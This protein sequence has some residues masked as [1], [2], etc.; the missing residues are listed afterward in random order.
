MK[1][2][3]VISLAAI[4][5]LNAASIDEAFV[6]GKVSGQIRAAYVS[7]NN[8]VD[9]DTYGTSIGGILKYETAAWNDITLGVGAYVSQKLNF[10][11][12]DFDEG[13]ANSDLFGEDT[14]SYAYIGEG[15]IDYSANDIAVRVGRQLIDTPFADTDNIRMHPNTF[16]AAIVT[17]TGIEE[18]T[19]VGGYIS[20][21]AGYDSENDISKFKKVAHDSSGVAVIGIINESIENLELKGWY[22]SF[23]KLTNI[24]Y[25]D[26]SYTIPFD[27]TN[28]LELLGQWMKFTE[29]NNSGVDG[30]AYGIGA[31]ITIGMLTLGTAYNEASNDAGKFVISGL[32][33]GPYL[34]DTEEMNLD[35]FEDIKAYLFSAELDMEEVGVDGLT[36]TAIYAGFKSE[37]VDMKEKEINLIAMYDINKALSV[38]V[39]YAR[40]EDKNNNTSE[41]GLYN[42]GYDRF[43]VRMNYNF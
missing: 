36:L 21:W 1:K 9:T 42:G 17:Y 3:I 39:N 14:K 22:Y 11:T 41:D 10:A 23:D 43:L 16:E 13:K 2:V 7:Q 24:L 19:L 32:G 4:V 30:N 35:Y 18:T 6:D 12:G 27:E 34:V 20:G 28:G 38:E 8:K 29:K 25:T 40:L 5:A 37:P 15:Y 26:A 33:N 31:N